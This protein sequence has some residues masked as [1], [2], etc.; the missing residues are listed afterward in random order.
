MKSEVFNRVPFK[1]IALSNERKKT[2]SQKSRSTDSGASVAH[3]GAIDADF[4]PAELREFLAADYVPVQADPAFKETLRK[5]L[6][7]LVSNR[8]GPTSSSNK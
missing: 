7:T 8:A 6:W 2:E 4:T 5:K 3:D 1:D